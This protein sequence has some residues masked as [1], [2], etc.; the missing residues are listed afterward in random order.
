MEVET[1]KGFIALAFESG[2][3]WL[4]GA[5]GGLGLILGRWFERRKTAAEAKQIDAES[6][7]TLSDASLR[8]IT[9]LEAR[10]NAQTARIDLMDVENTGM[11]RRLL[12]LQVDNAA[13]R[14][15]IEQHRRPEDPPVPKPFKLIDFGAST[16]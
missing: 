13:L 4:I 8:A 12:E 3:A 1:G 11:R 2:I 6:E 16:T 5:G 10:V 14:Q 15:Y 9:A 7:A